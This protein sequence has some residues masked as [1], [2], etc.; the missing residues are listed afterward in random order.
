MKKRTLKFTVVYE[1]AEEGGFI[2]R[3]P[4]LPGCLTQGET[5]EE[6]EAM[7]RDAIK[8]YCSSLRKHGEPTPRDVEEIVESVLV[9]V[10]A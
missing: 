3:V 8:L 1:R 2:A 5:L 6:A 7:A 4:A 9:T 10:P